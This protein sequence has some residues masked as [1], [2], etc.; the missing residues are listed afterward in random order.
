MLSFSGCGRT[1]DACAPQ[2]STTAV[3]S[4]AVAGASTTD[5]CRI[6]LD[7]PETTISTARSSGA[8]ATHQ[9]WLLIRQTKI[10]A[11][12]ATRSVLLEEVR[13]G[14]KKLDQCAI[15]QATM[16]MGIDYLLRARPPIRTT[17]RARRGRGSP[18]ALLVRGEVPSPR[19]PDAR[20]RSTREASHRRREGLPITGLLS[21][22]LAGPTCDTTPAS[23]SLLIG[24]SSD[25]VTSPED[26][27]IGKATPARTFVRNREIEKSLMPIA[28]TA[29]SPASPF[30]GSGTSRQ[31]R[32]WFDVGSDPPQPQTTISNSKDVTRILRGLACGNHAHR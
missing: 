2:S 21:R 24:F 3:A 12:I 6:D 4:L 5:R 22:A 28:R 27:R 10:I 26:V 11:V 19:S 7:P 30:T 20:G 1:P 25:A 15:G 31:A 13:S 32:S 17:L 23:Q 16:L 9:P 8:S 29:P 18:E 14:T